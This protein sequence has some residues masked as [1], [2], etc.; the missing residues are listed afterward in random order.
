MDDAAVDNEENDED[1][2]DASMDGDNEDNNDR[3]DMPAPRPKHA[4]RSTSLEDMT[5]NRDNKRFHQ[6]PR[7][8][9]QH[10][11][12]PAEKRTGR[13][14]SLEQMTEQRQP[15]RQSA[16]NEDDFHLS[17][18]AE[19]SVSSN[20]DDEFVAPDIGVKRASRSESL[21]ALTENRRSKRSSV[22]PHAW[23]EVAQFAH[24]AASVGEGL[25]KTYK[26]AME[27]INA[28]NWSEACKAEINSL[29]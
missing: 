29:L 12:V 5:E 13:S 17:D 20:Y 16:N 21:E 23:W 28:S 4:D 26:A 1:M 14:A 27:S 6:T 25:P 2:K 19:D 22:P 15:N 9:P 3:S 7:S 11:R 18:E 24:V 8:A 10:P